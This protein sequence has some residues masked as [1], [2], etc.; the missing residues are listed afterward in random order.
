[1]KSL[2]K[3]CVEEVKLIFLR[4]CLFSYARKV[5]AKHWKHKILGSFSLRLC[6]KMR[7]DLCA[8]LLLTLLQ[9]G[10]VGQCIHAHLLEH[11]EQSV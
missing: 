10:F 4:L 11:G 1:M 9:F 7:K 2:V 3:V 6:E 8:D 5:T